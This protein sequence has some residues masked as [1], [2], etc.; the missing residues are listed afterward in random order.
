MENALALEESNL[1]LVGHM[2]NLPALALALG[3][4]VALPLNGMIALKRLDIGRYAEIWRVSPPA[5]LAE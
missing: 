2:P 1:L 3:V 5:P 4:A